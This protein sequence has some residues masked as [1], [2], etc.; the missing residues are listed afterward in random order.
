VG[1]NRA[2]STYADRYRSAELT[3]K[4]RA[5]RRPLKAGSSA[6]IPAAD[7]R[8]RNPY[9]GMGAAITTERLLVSVAKC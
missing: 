9:Q 8:R 5:N 2:T 4:D 7:L 3:F 1:S 6:L